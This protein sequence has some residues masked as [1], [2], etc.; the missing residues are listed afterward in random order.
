MILHAQTE[1]PPASYPEVAGLSERA[2]A[3]DPAALWQRIE[4]W[5]AYRWPARAVEWIVEGR[6]LWTPPLA[7]WTVTSVEQGHK[8]W[9]PVS[10][11]QCVRGLWLEGAMYR[12]TATVGS[13]DDPPAAVVEAFRRL[14]EYASE[15]DKV[16]A[17]LA[18]ESMAMG[19]LSWSRTRVATAKAQGLHLSGAADLLRPW[20]LA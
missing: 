9:Q 1:T 19:E 3:L 8:S 18:R 13:D 6:G 11:E 12:I 4:A 20:R 15:M 7:Q 16:P 17:G 10:L 14:A 2:A 5:I